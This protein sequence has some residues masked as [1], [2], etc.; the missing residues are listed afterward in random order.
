MDG[1]LDAVSVRDNSAA[2]RYEAEMDGQLAVITYWRSG[3]HITFLHT[4]VPAALEGHGIAGQMARVALDDAR[5]KG[6]AVI[7]RC[8]FIAAYIRRH[9][10]YTDLVPP[11]ERARY[12][13]RSGR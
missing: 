10:E 1:N 13:D 11:A 2:S 5:A 7:P 4:G 6:L 8:P 3:Q 9:P 12:L